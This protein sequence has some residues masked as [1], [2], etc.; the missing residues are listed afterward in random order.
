MAHHQHVEVFLEGVAGVG[1]CGVGAAGQHVGFAA[2]FD[3]VWSVPPACTLGMERVDGA[4]LDRGDCV[5]DK[6][7]FIQGVG[8]DADLHIHLIRHRQTS[9]NGGG[10]CS[11]VFVE[12]EAASPSPHLFF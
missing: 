10:C 6:P 2:D 9:V 4:P 7:R 1:A 8:V 12:F 5:F 3:D 11:P